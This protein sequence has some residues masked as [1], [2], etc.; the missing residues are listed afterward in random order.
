MR[1]SVMTAVLGALMLTV[2]TTGAFSDALE[3]P[4]SGGTGRWVI[5]AEDPYV[6]GGY[7]DNFAYD[8]ENVRPLKGYLTLD[9]DTKQKRGRIE[10]VLWTTEESGPVDWSRD[11]K[12]TGEIRWVQKFE[13]AGNIEE[14]IWL[15]GDSGVE[16]PVLPVLWNWL[17]TW[18]PIELYVN[19]ELV[20]RQ[21]GHFM[22]SVNNRQ[23]DYSVS[24][25]DADGQRVYYDPTMRDTNGW[26][27][28]TQQQDTIIHVVTHSDTPD[29]GNFPPHSTWLHV[30]FAT[31]HVIQTPEGFQ[32][33]TK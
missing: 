32:L 7:G 24:K 3:T 15:H 21:G 23:E 19:D 14:F 6:I 11:E 17:G 1:R 22:F 13:G 12:F 30:N 10:A 2:G 5:T 29:S 28:S 27:T 4:I 18:A 31:V 16:A 9:L 26:F 33:S 8:G 25:L 20:A